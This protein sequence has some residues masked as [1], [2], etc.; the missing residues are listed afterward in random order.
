MKLIIQINCLNEE[1]DLPNAIAS[2]PKKIEGI[3]TIEILIVDDGS[4][5]KTREVAYQSGAHYVVRH[6]KNRGLPSAVNTGMRAALEKRADI[7]V[8]TDADNQYK[9]EDIPRLVK[10]IVDGTADYVYGERNIANIEHFSPIKKMFQ[11]FGAQVISMVLGFTIKDG[12]SGFR[13]INRETMRRLYLLA[14]FASPLES[15]IQARMKKLGIEIISIDVNETLRESRIVKSIPT[16][17]TKSASIIMDNVLIYRPMQ[18]FFSI[19]LLS[20]LTGVGLWFVRYLLVTVLTPTSTNLHL[21]LLVASIFAFVAGLQ[22]ITLGILARIL[23]ANRLIN[24]HLIYIQ[25]DV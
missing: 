20:A 17:V 7:L 6:N 19:G 10:P 22:L 24:E 16:Y 21:T 13:A 1:K 14:D 18:L 4:S 12:A 23:R 25:N 9:G 15:I 2:L 3:D 5:D 8:N 11:S